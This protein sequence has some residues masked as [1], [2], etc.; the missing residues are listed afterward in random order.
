MTVI[1][2]TRPRDGFPGG[3]VVRLDRHSPESSRYGRRVTVRAAD[4][5]PPV[6]SDPAS[7][8][9]ARLQQAM[10]RVDEL[11]ITGMGVARGRQV[12][13]LL[14]TSDDL[15]DEY[16]RN[17]ISP[18]A[19]HHA[20]ERVAASKAHGSAL[21]ILADRLLNNM[22]SSQPMCFN[23]LSDLG[24]LVSAGDR[25]AVAALQL[26]FPEAGIRSAQRITVEVAPEPIGEY[27]NDLTGWDAAVWINDGEG[28]ISIETKYTDSLDTAAPMRCEPQRAAVARELDL[29][30]DQGWEHFDDVG[31]RRNQRVVRENAKRAA[32][33]KSLLPLID[34][35]DF[36]QM[37]RNILLT[38]VYR[39]RNDMSFASNYVLAPEFDRQARREVSATAARLRPSKR[40]LVHYRTLDDAVDAALTVLA[41]TPTGDVL[42]VFRRRYLDLAVARDAYLKGS[43]TAPQ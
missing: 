17:L 21:T 7:T 27:L 25:E 15:E 33:G 41:G 14:P 18:A 43:T 37:A 3:G 5:G 19:R 39:V 12:G 23:L 16:E 38:E 31:A 36:D 4:F 11:R 8:G 1:D 24:E 20:R 30:T 22:L 26:M 42:G 34:G 28:V 40:G 2:A 6:D 32:K 29:F 35:P 9:I 10:W 13:S